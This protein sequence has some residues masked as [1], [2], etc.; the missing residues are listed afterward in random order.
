[1]G[2]VMNYRWKNIT[3]ERQERD[4]Y[5][6]K[7]DE[8]CFGIEESIVMIISHV[9]ILVRHMR[10]YITW[11]SS[12]TVINTDMIESM[13]SNEISKVKSEKRTGALKTK[14]TETCRSKNNQWSK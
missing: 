10:L 2:K 13:K 1:M 5:E 8:F 11:R 7:Y 14:S 4:I 12:F 9:N 6:E 3:R